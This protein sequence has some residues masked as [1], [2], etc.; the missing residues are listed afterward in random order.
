MKIARI[1]DLVNAETSDDTG[2]S[3]P[4]SICLRSL[5]RA[6]AGP[7]KRSLSVRD[8]P[9]GAQPTGKN[10]LPIVGVLCGGFI[11]IPKSFWARG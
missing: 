7:A 9:H 4:N 3:K 10:G 11:A 6:W 5:R 8:P 2:K 1:N